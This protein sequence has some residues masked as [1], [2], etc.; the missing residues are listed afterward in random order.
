MHKAQIIVNKIP[1]KVLPK[2][3]NQDQLQ[4]EQGQYESSCNDMIKFF[5]KWQKDYYTLFIKYNNTCCHAITRSRSSS[6]RNSIP[7]NEQHKMRDTSFV[8]Q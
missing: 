6:V 4:S 7:R 5:H 3:T 8:Q 1:V 2:N